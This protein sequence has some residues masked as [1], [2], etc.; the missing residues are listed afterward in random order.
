[1]SR[2]TTYRA[3][4]H[5]GTR[6]LII[7]GVPALNYQPDPTGPVAVTINDPRRGR[8]LAKN[9]TPDQLEQ[10]YGVHDC[11]APKNT[12]RRGRAP[13]QRNTGSRPRAPRRPGPAPIQPTLI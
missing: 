4:N 8:F 10:R 5:C 11:G 7:R 2:R 1:M 9:E 6:L 12:H 13:N 3:C